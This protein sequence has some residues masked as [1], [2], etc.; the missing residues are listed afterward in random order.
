MD[1]GT[2]LFKALR[3]PKANLLSSTPD[4]VLELGAGTGHTAVQLL[5]LWPNATYIATD[6]PARVTALERL[7]DAASDSSPAR[8]DHEHKGSHRGS[9]SIAEPLPRLQ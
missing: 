5:Q 3:D 8:F 1:S 4:E 2:L 9:E 7:Q 6:L